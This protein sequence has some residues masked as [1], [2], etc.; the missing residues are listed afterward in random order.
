MTSR[1]RLDG[2]KIGPESKPVPALCR[3]PESTI[4]AIKV[5]LSYSKADQ[6]HLEALSKHLKGLERQGYILTWSQREVELGADERRAKDQR[7]AHAD[8]ILLLVSPD[9]VGSDDCWDV[10]MARALE[11]H[12]QGT[13]RLVPVIVRPCDWTLLPFSKEVRP[14]PKDGKAVTLWPNRDLAWTDVARRLR[15][16]VEGMRGGKADGAFQGEPETDPLPEVESGPVETW[17]DPELGLRFN[18]VPPGSFQRGSP[19]SEKG[20]FDEEIP[21]H[22]ELT[23][24]F[25]IAQTPVRVRDYRLYIED[26]GQPMPPMQRGEMHPV[27]YVNWADC[28]GF[29]SWLSRRT[30]EVIRLPTEAEWECA[31]R[32]GTVEATYNGNLTLD[33]NVAPELDDI[34]WYHDNSEGGTQPV[35]WKQP[36]G[37]GLYDMLGNVCE[38][39]QDFYEPYRKESLRDPLGPSR[40]LDRVVRGG[41]WDS[42]PHH[43]RAAHRIWFSPGIR[44]E[45]VGFRLVR[46]TAPKRGVFRRRNR[47]SPWGKR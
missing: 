41:S 31:A 34:A 37:L 32:A 33:G 7:L 10:E 20:R 28:D 45:Y 9:F 27:V 15:K 5:F 47:R 39:T 6:D 24:E 14:W 44:S 23:R 22:V 29:C 19:E 3:F 1:E 13:A 43:C 18:R 46:D 30:G 38:W 12:R 4:D 2:G 42:H 17:I 36:N 40:G 11:R 8:L 16:T 21:H 26:T 35:A 25:W